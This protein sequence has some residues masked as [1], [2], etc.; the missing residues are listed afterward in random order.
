M[1]GIEDDLGSVILDIEAGGQMGP[2][3][4]KDGQART[5][6]LCIRQMRVRRG[7]S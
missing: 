4:Q 3:G 7:L 1:G 5:G 6:S 2:C